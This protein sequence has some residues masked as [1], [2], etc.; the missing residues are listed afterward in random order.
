MIGA[1]SDDLFGPIGFYDVTAAWAKAIRWGTPRAQGLVW[2]SRQ[3]DTA[4][5]LM[6]WRDRVGSRILQPLGTPEPIDTGPGL[7]RVEAFAARV[8][9]VLV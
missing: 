3:D 5:A 7:R 8:R 2:M 4:R 1:S 6:L 9:I